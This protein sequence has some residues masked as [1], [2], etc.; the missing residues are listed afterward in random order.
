MRYN[1]LK[2]SQICPAKGTMSKEMKDILEKHFS[3]IIGNKPPTDINKKAI[4][5]ALSQIKKIIEGKKELHTHNSIPCY[6]GDEDEGCVICIGN[7]KLD[8]IAKLFEE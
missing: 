8:D 4:T 7:K 3:I 6:T 2:V 5:Q 1:W